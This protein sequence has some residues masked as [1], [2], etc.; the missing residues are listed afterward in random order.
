MWAKQRCLD[1]LDGDLHDLRL[2]PDQVFDR[3][4]GETDQVVPEL[5]QLI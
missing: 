1:S 2:S 4:Y 3:Q 5:T